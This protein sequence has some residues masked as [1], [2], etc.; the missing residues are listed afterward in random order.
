MCSLLLTDLSFNFVLLYKLFFVIV[1]GTVC[2]MSLLIVFDPVS[3]DV[4]LSMYVVLLG[5]FHQHAL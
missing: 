3:I 2:I 5:S 4:C 1:L